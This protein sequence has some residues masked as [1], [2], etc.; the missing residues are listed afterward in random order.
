MEIGKDV[1]PLLVSERKEEWGGV[2]R[3]ELAIHRR[4]R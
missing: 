3:N 1:A 4:R 2:S